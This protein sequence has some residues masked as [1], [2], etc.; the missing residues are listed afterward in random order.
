MI[1]ARVL[2]NDAPDGLANLRPG[3][4]RRQHLH[5]QLDVPNI[6]RLDALH[7][8]HWNLGGPDPP[9]GALDDRTHGRDAVPDGKLHHVAV[10]QVGD[11]FVRVIAPLAPAR[12]GTRD[13]GLVGLHCQTGLKREPP[14]SQQRL[15][16]WRASIDQEY[17]DSS[18]TGWQT[19]QVV[20]ATHSPHGR[21]DLEPI[22]VSQRLRHW[23]ALLHA[24]ADWQRYA[25]LGPL[26]FTGW[27]AVLL[28]GHVVS[29]ACQDLQGRHA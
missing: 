16:F 23:P 9:A 18:G 2:R 10:L 24:D 14:I 8:G 7:F 25:T 15:F 3:L 13:K 17:R 5:A 26:P 21:D 1:H 19:R 27:P 11:A 20:K 12:I 29:P 6:G 4:E 22:A 28:H